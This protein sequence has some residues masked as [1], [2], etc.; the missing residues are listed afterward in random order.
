M[1]KYLVLWH[2][3]PIA[4]WPVDPAKY[5]ELEEMIWAGMDGLIKKGEVK[6]LGY[7]PNGQ[8]GYIIGEGEATTLY[9]NVLMFQPYF[10]VEVHEIISYEN[11]KEI[12]RAVC[13]ARIEAAKK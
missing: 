12:S 1:A 10:M 2:A 13:R 7:Y 3:N 9:K 6:E 11:H 8:G 4:P 5:L